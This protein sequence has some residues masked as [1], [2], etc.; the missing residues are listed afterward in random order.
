MKASE[1]ISQ[2]HGDRR[3]LWRLLSEQSN[4]PLPK[5]LLEDM[6]LT[7]AQEVALQQGAQRLAQHEP[8]AYIS[9]KAWF[10]D[11]ELLVDKR[12]LIPRPDTETLVEAVLALAEPGRWM[13][14][15]TGSGAIAIA[16]AK[17]GFQM[18]ATD[19]SQDAL[20]VAMANARHNDV[21]GIHWVQGDLTAGLTGPWDGIVSNPPYIAADEMED[22][23]PSVLWEPHAA[24]YGGTDG[25]D[26]YKRLAECSAL[27]RPGGWMALEIGYQQANAVTAIFSDK[28][29][30][31]ITV[32]QDLGGRD[33]VVCCRRDKICGM[34]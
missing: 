32:K 9:G 27:L 34:D 11:C 3:Q 18:T 1:L 31:H 10:M 7:Q 21:D 13:E 22:L 25:L 29:W 26:F 17:R 33:R 24:L 30:H 4:I 12:V 16:L 19:I 5:L 28:G 8:I 2:L 23:D 14:V 6:E 20:D 15:G